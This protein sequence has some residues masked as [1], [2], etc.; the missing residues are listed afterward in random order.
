M[1]KF[2]IIFSI[3]ICSLYPQLRVKAEPVFSWPSNGYL[4]WTY[5]YPNG[6]TNGH[7]GI[8]I[9]GNTS[10]AWGNGISPNQGDGSSWDIFPVSDGQIKYSSTTVA[11]GGISIKHSDNLYSFYWHVKGIQVNN[12]DWVT[13]DSLLGQMNYHPSD[14]SKIVHV[15]LTIA[16]SNF[17][18]SAIDPSPYFDQNLDYGSEGYSIEWMKPVT[19]VVNSA[20]NIICG[21]FVVQIINKT[22]TDSIDCKAQNEIILSPETRIFSGSSRFYIN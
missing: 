14:S 9:W 21:A 3:L 18:S 8:D 4:G 20:N 22:I 17:D 15:H 19:R 12:D 10:G 7:N 6:T 1:K 16:D 5:T 13:R 11:G 2:F